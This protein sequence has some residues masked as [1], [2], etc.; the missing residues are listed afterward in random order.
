V[1]TNANA[2]AIA[3]ATTRSFNRDHQNLAL[4]RTLPIETTIFRG[5]TLREI[6]HRRSSRRG[7]HVHAE[8]SFPTMHRICGRIRNFPAFEGTRFV[9]ILDRVIRVF[10]SA[11][12]ITAK[13]LAI[14]FTRTS[15]ISIR[16]TAMTV[17]GSGRRRNC[18]FRND[19]D[20]VSSSRRPAKG[21]PLPPVP[22]S[23]RKGARR[24]SGQRRRALLAVPDGKSEG[25]QIDGGGTGFS[26]RCRVLEEGSTTGSHGGGVFLGGNWR[27]SVAVIICAEGKKACWF[28][29]LLLL[30][31]LSLL[32]E[33]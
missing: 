25:G 28:L 26:G 10:L 33:S 32:G 9:G 3:I 12:A 17:E 2:I 22:R 18:R 14:I 13:V 5:D 19:H 11:I 16:K 1:R 4:G 29:L 21:A 20:F 24:R 15:I 23:S 6:Q 8:V 27:G 30:L 7:A 31:V